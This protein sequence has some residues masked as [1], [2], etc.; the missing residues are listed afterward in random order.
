MV[1]LGSSWAR[2]LCS[3]WFHC[4]NWTRVRQLTCL[5]CSEALWVIQL[6]SQYFI[7]GRNNSLYYH[8]CLMCKISLSLETRIDPAEVQVKQKEPYS[9]YVPSPTHTLQSLNGWK[10]FNA[11]SV[12]IGFQ[13]YWALNREGAMANLWWATVQLSRCMIIIYRFTSISFE[14]CWEQIAKTEGDSQESKTLNRASPIW[15]LVV[16]TWFSFL[17]VN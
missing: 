9:M 14:Y 1:L 15:I 12:R 10:M 7:T 16:R 13:W 3:N 8:C 2:L 17:S 5:L 4:R 11:I 6:R